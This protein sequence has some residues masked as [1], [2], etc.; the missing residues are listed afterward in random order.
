MNKI[1]LHFDK[2]LTRLAGNQY[3][4]TVYNEQVKNRIKW[5]EQ[6]EIVFPQEIDR[7]AI[8]FI[9]GFAKEI[10]KK[11]DKTDVEKLLIFKASSNELENKIL[12]NILF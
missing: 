1:C 10:L 7:V 2:T 6:N 12:D 3:G 4:E 5:N 9:Q 8:S 11:I